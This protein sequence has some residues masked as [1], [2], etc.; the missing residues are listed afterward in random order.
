MTTIVGYVAVVAICSDYSGNSGWFD[1]VYSNCLDGLTKKDTWTLLIVNGLLVFISQVLFLLP[2]FRF[3]PE[4]GGQKSMRTSMVIAAFWAAILTTSLLMGVVAIVQ[5]LTGT[6]D[7]YPVTLYVDS[8][9]L[10]IGEDLLMTIKDEFTWIFVLSLVTLLTSW[11]LWSIVLFAFIARRSMPRAIRRVTGLLVA[12]TLLE[13]LLVLPLEAMIRR[14]AECYCGTGS[15]QMLLGSV[16]AATWLLGP[17]LFLLLVF[18]R[19]AYW[20][21]FCADCG[22]DKGPPSSQPENCPE[23]GRAWNKERGSTA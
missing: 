15:F 2:V 8:E 9:A 20:G 22:Y 3:N 1:T 12:G 23:C 5:L 21:R 19:P 4:V 17:G 6:L 14:R 18:R 11:L 13:I 7:E 16:M 10:V